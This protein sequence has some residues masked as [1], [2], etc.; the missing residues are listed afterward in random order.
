MASVSDKVGEVIGTVAGSGT[1]IL[2]FILGKIDI[3]EDIHSLCIASAIALFTG[4]CGFIG[5]I[6][7]KWVIETLKKER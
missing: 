6:L 3:M 5:T 7:G 1:G 4:F 2:G